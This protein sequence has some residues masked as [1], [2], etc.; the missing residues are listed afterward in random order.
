MEEA[1]LFSSSICAR[2]ERVDV[3]SD[4][5]KSGL[6][7]VLFISTSI[8]YARIHSTSSAIYLSSSFFAKGSHRETVDRRID[9][10]G[11]KQDSTVRRVV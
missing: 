4:L 2:K 6:F 7:L 3:I 1:G 11:K 10:F 9:F 8:M 5:A